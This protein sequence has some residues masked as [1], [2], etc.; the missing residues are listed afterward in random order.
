[1][2]AFFRVFHL[3]F[4]LIKGEACLFYSKGR[5]KHVLHRLF[6]EMFEETRPKGL[7][8]R[9]RGRCF[10]HHKTWTYVLVPMGIL[11][12]KLS[13]SAIDLIHWNSWKPFFE[14][15]H[16]SFGSDSYA[17]TVRNCT[18]IE[19]SDLDW[20]FSDVFTFL[21]FP[22]V[23]CVLNWSAFQIQVVCVVN[24]YS[25]I[26][27]CSCSEIFFSSL[28]FLNVLNYATLYSSSIYLVVAWSLIYPSYHLQ[29][30][31]WDDKNETGLVSFGAYPSSLKVNCLALFGLWDEFL[32]FTEATFSGLVL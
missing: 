1:M 18:W 19:I 25:W 20:L 14:T 8:H 13:G 16:L 23:R 2:R 30:F 7:H 9:V 26:I 6:L 21:F 11:S 24:A 12:T 3:H 5:D 22:Y 28:A 29:P 32:C 31:R 17:F 15:C 27:P 4:L 10:G